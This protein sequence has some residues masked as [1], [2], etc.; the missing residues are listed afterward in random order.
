MNMKVFVTLKYNSENYF[1]TQMTD[2]GITRVA[3][4]TF[5]K[6]YLWSTSKNEKTL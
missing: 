1:G 2:T 4:L 3:R 6:G 5:V